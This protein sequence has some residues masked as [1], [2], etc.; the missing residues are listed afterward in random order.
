MI[1]NLRPLRPLSPEQANTLA[2]R[3]IT[4]MHNRANGFVVTSA[5]TGAHNL[6][7]YVRSDF[8]RLTTVRI[9]DSVVDIVRAVSDKYIGEPN[10]A[11]QRN[12]L[13]NE[14]EK[15]LKQLRV[16]QALRDWQ[17][18]ISATPDQQVLGEA[19]I[20]L[21]LVPAFELIKIEANISLAKQL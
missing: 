18:Y 13:A 20:D 1:P 11:A 14:I 15:F 7:K 6:S 3:R 4:T 17:M 9:V 5:M 21:T 19:V 16:A 10:T 8:V 2:A 12:A